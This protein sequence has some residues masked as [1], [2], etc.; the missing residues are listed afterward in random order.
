MKKLILFTL[1]SLVI[2]SCRKDDDEKSE[3]MIVG[4]WTLTKNQVMSGK[5]N[6]I[7]FSEAITDCPDKRTYLF[8]ENNYTI[9]S[10]KD[11]FTGSCIIDDTENGEFNYDE[12]Q[13][14]ITFKS[15]R[16]NN[17]YTLKVNSVTNDEL[18]LI[19]PLYYYDVDNDGINDK[20]VMVL[21]K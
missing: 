1:A 20:F 6:S 8:S 21:N 5:D 19:N 13:K 3:S 2:I 4:T 18:Q 10:F 17:P 16:T 11:N 9:N 15:T 14:Q 12:N 7:L